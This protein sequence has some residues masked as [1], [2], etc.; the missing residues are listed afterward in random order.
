MRSCGSLT[1]MLSHVDNLTQ[2]AIS[3]ASVKALAASS[4][5]PL[6]LVERWAQSYGLDSAFRVCR[7]DQSVPVTAIR[8]RR[9]EAEEQIKA[10]GIEL[11]PGAFLVSARRVLRGDVTKTAAFRA[12]LCVIQ[13]E[14]SQLV[15]ALVGSG[16]AHP[17]LLCSSRRKNSGHRR[18]ESESKHLCRGSP[19]S[20]RAPSSKNAEHA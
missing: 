18:S 13:D 2:L 1:R 20:P 4:A 15:A 12:G 7:H 9:P 10:E 16:D 3:D 19:P 8:L 11:A 17:R 5:H 14:A 6:W